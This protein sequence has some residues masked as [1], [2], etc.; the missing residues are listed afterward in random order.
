M[1]WRWGGASAWA[2]DKVW[3]RY[4]D[5]EGKVVFDQKCSFV[6]QPINS[7][8]K[9]WSSLD[10]RYTLI[11]TKNSK[12]EVRPDCEGS[13][14]FVNGQSASSGTASVNGREY[15]RF[16]LGTGTLEFEKQSLSQAFENSPWSKSF[17][18]EGRIGEC[19]WRTA[20]K[21]IR[22]RQC[23]KLQNCETSDEVGEG[24][25]Q[26]DYILQGGA[27]EIS[28]SNT[29]ETFSLNDN[30]TDVKIEGDLTCYSVPMSAD[31]EFCFQLATSRQ[32]EDA[33]KKIENNCEDGKTVWRATDKAL[34][35][36]LTIVPSTK[37]FGH[38]VK[39]V[40][41]RDNIREWQI[42]GA[43][44]CSLGFSICRVSLPTMQEDSYAQDIIVERYDADDNGNSDWVILAA[45]AQQLWYGGGAKVTW[46]NQPL[47]AEIANRQ[48]IPNVFRR[49]ECLS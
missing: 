21:I 30:P 46:L 1:L 39:I 37:F 49:Y 17:Q 28:I 48:L 35:Y 43:L 41:T 9:S 26:R 5:G 32:T 44:S 42:I 24:G 15:F 29:E 2:D 31:T 34:T 4:L 23:Q 11:F 6:L 22:R 25:C 45:A 18:S 10:S 47:S 3:C 8:C 16:G 19:T 7:N 27:K 40:R 14:V 38:D 13:G 12:T 33:A 20:G 36:Y